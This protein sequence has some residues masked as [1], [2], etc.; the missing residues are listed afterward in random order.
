M[1]IVAALSV[2]EPFL[3]WLFTLLVDVSRYVLV[4]GA[5]FAIFWV[6]LGARLHRRWL[7]RETV[8]KTKMLHDLKWSACTVLIFS[9]FGVAVRYA[10]LAGILRRYETVAEHGW[11]WFFSSILVLIVLQDTYFYWTH[12]AMHH[13]LLYRAVHREH[14]VSTHTSP[15]TAYAFSPWEA[16]VHASFV[17]LVWFVLPLH[18]IAV[19]AFLG[20]MIVRNVLGHLSIELQPSGST[21]S[22]LWGRLTTTTHHALH[23]R[24]FTSN[25]GL[26]LTF[27]DRVMGTTHRKYE[28]EFERVA[29]ADV[30]R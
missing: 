6:W 10:G 27:W 13:P 8:R 17:P 22:R 23:H 16:I 20:F 1:T 5:G 14:H 21:T 19:F 15:W 29:A 25:Y 3:V 9:I 24:H 2:P 30:Y 28:E 7:D 18:Q 11:L 12:R 26:Y 4:A